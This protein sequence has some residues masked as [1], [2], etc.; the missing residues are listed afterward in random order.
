MIRSFLTAR[1]QHQPDRALIIENTLDILS[2]LFPDDLLGLLHSFPDIKAAVRKKNHLIVRQKMYI[3]HKRFL[4]ILR[5]DNA[6]GIFSDIREVI[7][8]N[9]ALCRPVHDTDIGSNHARTVRRDRHADRITV[10]HI[11][12]NLHKQL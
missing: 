11:G 9:A 4:I 10:I 1:I 7:K 8:Y 3:R 6:V 5:S 12:R 2:H